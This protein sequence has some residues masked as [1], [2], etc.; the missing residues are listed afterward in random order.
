MPFVKVEKILPKSVKKAGII[1]ELNSVK[2]LD[3]FPAVIEKMFGAAILKKIKP[4]YLKNG[5]LTVGCLYTVLGQQLKA[6]E[7]MILAELNRPYRKKVV[8]KL[9]FLV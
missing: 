3:E 2:I 7:K 8:E 6:D 4:L 1:G 5:T 9:R